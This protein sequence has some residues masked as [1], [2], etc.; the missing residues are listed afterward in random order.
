MGL[1]AENTEDITFETELPIIVI[2]AGPVGVQFVRT[3]MQCL[4][5]SRFMLFGNE[6]W[7]PYNRVKLSSFFAGQLHWDEM[8]MSQELASSDMLEIVHNCA[9]KKIDRVKKTVTDEEG[10]IYAYKKLVLAT[11]SRPFIPKIP[12]IHAEN[13]FTFRDMSD[14]EKLSARRTRSRKTIVVGG[15]VLGIEAARAMSRENTEVSIIDHLPVLMSNQLDD[16]AAEILHRHILSQGIGLYLGCGIREF[17]GDEK[18][19]GLVLKDG[20]EINCDTVILATGIRPNIE[21]AVD[22]KLGTNRGIRVNDAMQTTDENIIAVGECAE[23]RGQIYG[24]VKPGYEQAKV[25]A[26]NLSGQESNYTGS[27]AATQLKVVDMPAFSMGNIEEVSIKS[28]EREL[29]YKDKE[30]NIYRRLVIK[31]RK[32]IGAISI[33]KWEE[34]NRVQEAILNKRNVWFWN[35][36]RFLKTGRLWKQEES[37]DV[38]QWPASAIVCNCNGVSRGQ[39]TSAMNGGLTTVAEI[40]QCTGASSVC[41][42]CKPLVSQMLMSDVKPEAVKGSSALLMLGVLSS[43]FMLLVTILPSIP[44]AQ[45][46]Q[47]SWQWDTLWRDNIFKQISGFT[48]LGLS[49]I[50]LM[51]SLRKRIKKFT[52]INFSVWRIVHVVA[53]FITVFGLAVHS[54][55]SFGSGVNYFL[56]LSFISVLFAGGVSSVMLA[57]EHKLDSVMSRRIKSK[58]VWLHIIAF[59]PLPA[60]LVVHIFKSY[61]F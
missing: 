33:G 50:V 2:G 22:S 17:T 1:V 6:P 27:L 12:G 29:V 58:L 3:A 24:L 48:L 52:L 56:A 41:G 10:C 20:T 21:L 47:H 8:M 38:N 36:K 54:G 15:G 9:I 26:Y 4:P 42:S 43:L 61:Y 34:Q 35:K 32:I 57:I 60:L 23:H 39:I 5:T 46:M 37:G 13:V 31:N 28:L 53:G 51:M 11:G 55:Y 59:W 40:T 18:V 7:E 16:N 14:I 19:T 49:V 30:K 44:Y 45:T 25:A